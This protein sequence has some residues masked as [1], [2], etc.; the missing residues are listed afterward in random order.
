MTECWEG[1][2]PGFAQRLA[3]GKRCRTSVAQNKTTSVAPVLSGGGDAWSQGAPN[4]AAGT[5]Y[6]AH[7]NPC[8]LGYKHRSSQGNVRGRDAGEQPGC[9]AQ[10]GG[11]CGVQDTAEAT[12]GAELAATWYL[13]PWQLSQ[14][15]GWN[16][17]T[18][19][20]LPTSLKVARGVVSLRSHSW[21]TC[22]RL[23]QTW[24]LAWILPHR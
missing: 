12:S 21:A 3:W 2:F 9:G 18:C 24:F 17:S 5:G 1:G 8:W 6:E 10:R 23:S 4:R 7:L 22:L 20:A 15:S 11:R 14:R 13:Q 19:S 16:V